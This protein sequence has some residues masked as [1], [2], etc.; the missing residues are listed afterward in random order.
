MTPTVCV[1]GSLAR[2]CTICE[3]DREITALIAE[4][5][6][7]RALWVAIQ[8]FVSRERALRDSLGKGGQS[9]G[10]SPSMTVSTL[11]TLERLIRDAP[12]VK[13]TP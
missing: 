7:A 9:C 11:R 10:D 2:Q 1:H 13:E 8:T 12:A 4:R 3:R 6:E 5:D